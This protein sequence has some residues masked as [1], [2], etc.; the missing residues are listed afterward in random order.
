VHH[1]IISNSTYYSSNYFSSTDLLR[2]FSSLIEGIT[3]ISTPPPR[4]APSSESVATQCLRRTAGWRG[5]GASPR[6]VEIS[7]VWLIVKEKHAGSSRRRLQNDRE[8][9]LDAIED[10]RVAFG[11]SLETLDSDDDD[12]KLRDFASFLEDVRNDL[13]LIQ[14][15]ANSTSGGEMKALMA[16]E[17]QLRCKLTEITGIVAVLAAAKRA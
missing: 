2:H 5:L 10:L 11:A 17:K 6:K 14:T 16:E 9:R 12:R 4:V 8:V 13:S 7:N 3:D 1:I 15:K